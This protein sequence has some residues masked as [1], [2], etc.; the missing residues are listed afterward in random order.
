MAT[1]RDVAIRIE[2]ELRTEGDAWVD[3]MRY[4]HVEL[5]AGR[6]VPS[7]DDSRRSDHEEAAMS[8]SMRLDGATCS[9][10]AK[11]RRHTSYWRWALTVL[12]S[13]R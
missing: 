4:S 8:C 3:V 12:P 5:P 7:S 1:V 2:A 6:S 9:S 10:S 13:A 11:I